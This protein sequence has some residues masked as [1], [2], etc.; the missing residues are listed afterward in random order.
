M[1]VQPETINGNESPNTDLQ[2]ISLSEMTLSADEINLLKK[3]F[4]FTPTP[5]FNAFEWV[6]DVYL[7]ARRLA[8][9]K[10]HKIQNSDYRALLRRDADA[11]IML[12]EL[13][14][15]NETGVQDIKGP[16]TILRPKTSFT[17]PLRQYSSI[18]TFVNK[19]VIN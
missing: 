3:G 5:V 18:D 8:L 4:T 6:K 19:L 12:E 1:G 9:H 2:V 14:R 15:E 10:F 13:E 7:F 11:I 17:P 16:F